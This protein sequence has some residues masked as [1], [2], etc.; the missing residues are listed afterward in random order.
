M[1]SHFPL[2][3]TAAFL[4][5]ITAQLAV[6]IVLFLKIIRNNKGSALGVSVSAIRKDVINTV[7]VDG[8]KYFYEPKALTV[9]DDP[10]DW[11]NYVPHYTINKD[12]LNERF[13]YSEKKPANVF[14]II[15]VGDSYTFGQ[16]VSTPDNWTELLEDYLNQYKTCSKAK[17][18]EVINLGVGGYDTAYEV[19]RYKLRGQKYNP[20]LVIWYV[21]DMYRVTDQITDTMRRS[22]PNQTE[23]NMMEATWLEARNNIIRQRG[24]KGLADYQ[25][26]MM[27]KLR[28]EY[29]K[30]NPLLF[31]SSLKDFEPP[32]LANIHHVYTSIYDDRANFLPDYHFNSRGHQKFM[33]EIVQALIADSLL[34]CP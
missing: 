20:D 32:Q 13:N 23:Q 10:K 17:K 11:L 21:T 4:L 30:N 33:K 9:I 7:P 5:L 14:R 1:K 28:K 19:A 18:Y 16:Y 15:T 29:Y 8:L 12:A 22:H 6:V 3:K 26:S 24:K 2:V 34:P 25:L 27:E 31:V